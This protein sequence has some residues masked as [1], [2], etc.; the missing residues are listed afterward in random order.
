MTLTTPTGLVA[1]YAFEEGSG[2]K[3]SD[4]SGH[5]LTGTIVGATWTT[6]GKYD[7]ALSFD[8]TSSYV[9]LGNPT[10]LQLTGSMTWSAWVNAA[11]NP[12]DD[13]Q[14]IAKSNGSSGWQFKTSPD[15]GPHT[16][17][18]AVSSSSTKM[19][20]RYSKTVRALNTWYYVAGVYNASAK[21]LDIYVNGVLDDGVLK[22]T[23]P[24][25]QHNVSVNVNIGRRAGGFYF[26]GIID[27][28]RVYNRALTQVEIQTDMNTQLSTLLAP[29]AASAQV[30]EQD[31]D[32]ISAGGVAT[33]TLVPDKYGLEQNY[34]N[35]FNPSTT[36]RYAIPTE[37]HVRLQLFNIL[38]GLVA[39]LVDQDQRAGYYQ[40][41]FDAGRLASG[42]YIYRIQAMGFVAS[43]KLLLMK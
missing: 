2:T 29:A 8:G 39:T 11:A 38:G 25:S 1:A 6:S 15:T 21:T 41:T 20:Q 3:V 34:P 23:V 7:K 36:L 27:E 33:K 10:A 22:G 30:V 9:D 16:F 4:A 43:K 24:S 19:I 17:G 18:V 13:G 42:V 32:I 31:P 5:G 26:N 12:P 35:P 14:I 40:A 28:V 37:G